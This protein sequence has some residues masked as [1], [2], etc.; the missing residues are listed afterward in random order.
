MGGTKMYVKKAF[1][2]ICIISLFSACSTTFKTS[3]VQLNPL[4]FASNKDL[5]KESDS[6]KIIKGDQELRTYK[7]VSYGKFVIV[8]RD[9]LKFKVE[10]THKWKAYAEACDWKTTIKID[11]KTYKPACDRRSV[12][13]I[14][15]MWSEENRR[16]VS[17]NIYG[18]PLEIEGFER[19]PTTLQS[20]TIFVG[21]A[22]LDLYEKN[23]ITK[24]TKHIE[25]RMQ[26][27]LTIYLFV[28]DLKK[29]H[30]D[31]GY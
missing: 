24:N 25:L 11:G 26:K 8:S 17:R 13:T 19:N 7:T 2:L 30:K 29:P 15:W 28:W 21:K 20:I 5:V 27:N 22:S 23:I 6:L 18:D 12:D 16:V 4:Y 1:I 3:R 10:L 9:R 31:D 14:T